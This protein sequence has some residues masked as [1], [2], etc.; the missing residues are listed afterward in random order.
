MKKKVSIF[1]AAAM[2]LS[3]S[4]TAC[5]GGGGNESVTPGGSTSTGGGE[6]ASVIDTVDNPI[7]AD[8]LDLGSDFDSAYYP[9]KNQIEQRNGKID[10]VI[11]F[12]GAEDGW[13][14]LADEY[15]RLHGGEVLVNLNTTYS[16]GNY[17]DALK[18]EITNSN[19]DWD[20]V[21]GNLAT[22]LV[23][24]YCINMYPYVNGRNAYA[25]NKVWNE[26]IEEDAYITDKSGTN[27]STYIMNSESLLTAWFVNTV[28]LEAAGAKGYKNA[29]GEVGNPVTWDD[30]INLCKYMK[31]AG[32]ENPLGVSVNNEGI[33]AYSFSWLLRIYGDY[34][35]RNEYD[36]IMAADKHFVYDPADENPEGSIEYGVDITWLFHKILDDSSDKYIGPKS[37]KFKEF[38]GQIEKMSPYLNSTDA[39]QLSMEDLRNQFQT[40]NKG[41]SSP[42]ILLD[43]SGSGLAFLKNETDDYK[44]DFFDYPYMVSAGN[45]IPEGTVVRDVGGNGGYLSIINHGAKQNALNVDFMKFVM[46]P[47]GQSVYYDALSKT[48][49]APKG[50][51]LVRQN[52]VKVPDEWKN[53]FATDKIKFTGLV[54]SN[55]FIRNMVVSV[56]GQN[57]SETKVKLYQGLLAG[58]GSDAVDINAFSTEWASALYSGWV[59]YATNNNWNVNC[60]KYPGNG[61]SYG[62]E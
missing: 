35:F 7:T 2:A 36:G 58:K 37:A 41:K 53:F 44:I 9:V 22:N 17:T 48:N 16:S 38:L 31:E 26:V 30:L 6:S 15:S 60:Y 8:H 25:G 13:R 18:Y 33:N 27:T 32:Y 4:L 57:V 61:T 50:L 46:S 24:K 59:A 3:L 43:Y 52:L 62:G 51:T 12:D 14:A 5:G 39:T 19:T 11:L 34:Y 55:E 45:F 40:Q 54:D 21:Q 56:G 20:I 10:V 28:A 49:F 29:N 23:D 1:M 47:Y 42:Q